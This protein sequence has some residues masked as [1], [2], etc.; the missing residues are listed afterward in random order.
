MRTDNTNNTFK[1]NNVQ[2][3]WVT[4]QLVEINRD[5]SLDFE[6]SPVGL[7]R[8]QIRTTLA[9]INLVKF[10]AVCYLQQVCKVS[11]L[12]RYT[13]ETY[14]VSTRTIQE[15]QEKSNA[16]RKKVCLKKIMSYLIPLINGC[17]AKAVFTAKMRAC[18]HILT[19]L[20][21]SQPHWPCLRA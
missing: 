18:D 17:C 1:N 20:S 3:L 2:N 4:R 15:H 6:Y 11:P 19:Q 5:Y 8:V 13:N 9:V 7:N 14:F 12:D 10:Q 16:L 21:G